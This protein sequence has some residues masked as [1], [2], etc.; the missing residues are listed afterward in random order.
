MT[1]KIITLIFQEPE[2]PFNRSHDLANR[3]NCI[4]APDRLSLLQNPRNG[5]K[6]VYARWLAK[7]PTANKFNL[8]WYAWRTSISLAASAGAAG[9]KRDY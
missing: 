6:I 5:F 2:F 4:S 8:V 1:R 7:C 9:I 3:K